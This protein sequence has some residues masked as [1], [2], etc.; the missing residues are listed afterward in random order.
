MASVFNSAVVQALNDQPW[1]VRRKDSIAAVAGTVLQLA[2]I[3]TAYTTDSPA[4]VNLIVATVIGLCQLILHAKTQGAITPSMVSRL[5][6][7][8]MEAH[9]D[10][11][12]ASGVAVTGTSEVIPAHTEAQPTTAELPVYSGESSTGYQ[13]QHRA[14]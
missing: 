11:Q 14:E 13:G 9:L 5:E 7:A 8:G 4:W 3:A 12:S 6:L 1:W 2:N 10:R